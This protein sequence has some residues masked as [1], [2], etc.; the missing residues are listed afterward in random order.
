MGGLKQGLVC[1][2]GSIQQQPSTDK[3]PQQ[4]ILQPKVK[5]A[6]KNHKNVGKVKEGTIRAQFQSNNFQQRT[7][8]SNDP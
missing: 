6:T 8:F 4:I 7:N 1:Q 2:P 3:Q 5:A